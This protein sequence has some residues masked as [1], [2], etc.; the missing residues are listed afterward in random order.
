MGRDFGDP[1]GDYFEMFEGLKSTIQR[2]GSSDRLWL[3]LDQ[4]GSDLC[5]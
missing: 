1:R 4:D 2:R 5:P 3:T